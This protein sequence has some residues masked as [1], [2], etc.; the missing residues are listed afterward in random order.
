MLVCDD[1][2]MILRVDAELATTYMV[3][4][5][6]GLRWRSLVEMLLLHDIAF[7]LETHVDDE[8]Q[9]REQRGET[10]ER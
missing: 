7:V 1:Y 5:R 4:E 6:G 3:T 2:G 8:R 10:E 9:Q